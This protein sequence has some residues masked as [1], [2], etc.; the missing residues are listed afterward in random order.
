M[1]GIYVALV[2]AVASAG[3]CGEH[4]EAEVCTA[5]PGCV[6]LNFGCAAIRDVEGRGPSEEEPAR[7]IRR[8]ARGPSAFES[9]PLN[10]HGYAP[11][12][13]SDVPT[14]D[15]SS[16]WRDDDIGTEQRAILMMV[17]GAG[18]SAGGAVATA[19]GA[20][21]LVIAVVG[22]LIGAAA[23]VLLLSVWGVFAF[24][25]V[26]AG[27]ASVVGAG[28]YL[29]AGVAVLAGGLALLSRGASMHRQARARRRGGEPP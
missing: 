14:F 11:D 18:W 22:A 7:P 6:W 25:Y 1:L 16:L 20:V 27:V 4:Q 28:I 12:D 26:G 10:S 23:T 17:L 24:A 2:L 5:A 13:T 29:G 8:A 3:E 15:L 21:S 19:L 9:G